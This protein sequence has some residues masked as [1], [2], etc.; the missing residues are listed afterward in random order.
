M[1]LKSVAVFGNCFE[2]DKFHLFNFM[3]DTTVINKLA[4]RPED[5]KLLKRAGAEL[6]YEFFVCRIQHGEIIGMKSDGSFH[7][8][9]SAKDEKSKQM[10]TIMETLPIRRIPCLAAFVQSGILLDGTKYLTDNYGKL[11]DVFESV[12]NNNPVNIDD[13]IIVESGI[14]HNCVIVSNDWA[15]CK[16]TNAVYPE[17]AIW[18]ERFI[19][20]TKKKLV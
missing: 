2:P 20:E 6:A 11:Y 17:R 19:K 3:F 13:A 12:F 14:R 8:G 1:K 18:Y 9:F 15:M 4:E 7:K 10:S 16:N 5:V